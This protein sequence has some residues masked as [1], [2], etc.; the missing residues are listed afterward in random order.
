MN[1]SLRV[2]EKLVATMRR[3]QVGLSRSKGQTRTASLSNSITLRVQAAMSG[4]RIYP[5]LTARAQFSGASGGAPA[6]TEG[7]AIC[8]SLTQPRRAVNVHL[9]VIPA[10]PIGHR[11]NR[12]A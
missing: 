12:G 8:S 7:E 6:A 2:A 9:R 3:R 4:H 10:S 11:S 1:L 5:T